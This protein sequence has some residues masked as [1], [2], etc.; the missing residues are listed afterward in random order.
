M[1][2]TFSDEQQ[3]LHQAVRRFFD[4]NAQIETIRHIQASEL[5]HCE[6]LWHKIT[7]AGW[8]A[9]IIPERFGGAGGT[10]MDLA[11]IFEE[12]GKVLLPTSFYSTTYAT[13]VLNDLG[14][15][16]QKEHYLSK[17]ANG[18]FISTV[19][20]EEKQAL[21][22]SALFTTTAEA[23]NDQ[24]VINGEKWFVQNAHISDEMLVVARVG[25]QFGIFAISKDQEGVHLQEQHTV[26]R[27]K[28]AIVRF[29][30]VLVDTSHLIGERLVSADEL[31]G[32]RLMMTALQSVEMS[33][34]AMKVIQMTLD[35]VKERRQF[36]V[37]IGTFQAVQHHLSNLYTKAVGSRL[38]SYKAISV[39]QKNPK[40]KRE[41]SIAK[42]FTS[43]SYKD[44]TVMAHQLWGGMGYSTESHLFLWSNR[45]KAAELSFGTPALHRKVIE[46]IVRNRSKEQVEKTINV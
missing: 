1:K 5:G 17:I 26:G 13:L 30:Q 35:Y 29:E 10:I 3:M 11:I 32:S 40:A 14:T 27:D 4:K 39:L 22:K 33:G 36:G 21:T 7:E 37:A 20:Y 42:V 31:E 34:G 15:N 8:N 43:E 45:A 41:V 28:Q 16:T 2:M 44:I 18:E 25:K 23:M 6:N 38:S 19:A 46:Q 9:I 24:W 12:A